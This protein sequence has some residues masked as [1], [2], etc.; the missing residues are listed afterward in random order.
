MKKVTT[1][2]VEDGD[3][4]LK[5]ISHIPGTPMEMQLLSATSIVK[6]TGQSDVVNWREVGSDK[7]GACLRAELNWNETL[8]LWVLRP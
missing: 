5:Q 3:Y 2:V 1:F 7:Y 4:I 8:S 6:F